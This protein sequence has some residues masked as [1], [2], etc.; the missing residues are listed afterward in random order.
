[1][2]G[3]GG[4]YKHAVLQYAIYVDRKLVLN[5][6]ISFYSECAAPMTHVFPLFPAEAEAPI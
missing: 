6:I 5:V 1:M 2:G 4:N 3:G